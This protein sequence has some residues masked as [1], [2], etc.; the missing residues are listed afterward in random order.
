MS[1][2]IPLASRASVLAVQGATTIRSAHWAASMCAT[3]A[4]PVK[5]SCSTGWPESAS[6]VARPTI[7]SPQV[8]SAT[9]TSAPDSCRSLSSSTDL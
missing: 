1:S 6:K 8:V 9:R 5:T 3:E 2:D 7:F 4:S